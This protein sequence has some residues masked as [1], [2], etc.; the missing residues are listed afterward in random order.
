MELKNGFVD[1]STFLSIGCF[2]FSVVRNCLGCGR[3]GHRLEKC[4]IKTAREIGTLRA[5]LQ[6]RHRDNPRANPSRK[7][8]KKKERVNL[9]H[10]RHVQRKTLGGHLSR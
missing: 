9:L 1:K 10:A 3:P 5:K 2:Q 7:I 6:R 4:K 8:T